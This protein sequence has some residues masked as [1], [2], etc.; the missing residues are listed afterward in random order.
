MAGEECTSS[1]ALNSQRT[2]PG[3]LAGKEGSGLVPGSGGNNGS[4]E[5]ASGVLGMGLIGVVALVSG[6]VGTELVG[7]GLV[8][9]ELVST[10][11]NP[12]ISVLGSGGKGL[13]VLVSIFGF[14]G[15]F[16]L[17]GGL[18]STISWGFSLKNII[19]LAAPAPPKTSRPTII[20]TTNNFLLLALGAAVIG[21][22]EAGSAGCIG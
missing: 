8:G 17:A 14:A 11:G 10:P 3:F 18:T 16:G 1:P 15:G 2:V 4:V 7:E 21:W 9:T 12:G 6:V 13:E 20:P 5:L 22:G 19:Q